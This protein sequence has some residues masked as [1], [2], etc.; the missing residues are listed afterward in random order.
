MEA[1]R[2]LTGESGYQHRQT[3]KQQPIKPPSNE[4]ESVEWQDTA[5]AA[6][7]SLKAR[8]EEVT[9]SWRGLSEQTIESW[10][11]GF[12]SAKFDPSYG[13]NRPAFVMPWLS[14][15]GKV[16]NVKYRFTNDRES[17]LRFISI[18]GGN[19][20]IFG[21]QMLVRNDLLIVTEGEINALSL[22][23]ECN[24]FADVVSVGSDSNNNSKEYVNSLIEN[25]GYDQCLG[26]F[27]CPSKAITFRDFVPGSKT[28]TS[29]GGK[30]ANDI[31]RAGFSLR[32]VVEAALNANCSLCMDK[33]FLIIQGVC[34][35]CICQEAK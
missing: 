32:E 25:R 1:L 30:D 34:K 6:L 10:S 21:E 18:S 11:C 28:M 31:L 14:S 13:K 4:W 7:S 12:T 27:D 9:N 35:K 15:D 8:S 19:P 23:Q 29:P 5:R 3:Q 24:S 2:E 20:I 33:R 16:Y 26:W 17:K 22:W